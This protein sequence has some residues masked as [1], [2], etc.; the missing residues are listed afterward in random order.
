M[1]QLLL[2]D[3]EGL[4]PLLQLADLIDEHIEPFHDE[5]DLHRQ[6]LSSTPQGPRVLGGFFE[7]LRRRS[8]EAPAAAFPEQS[9]QPAEVDFSQLLGGGKLSQHRATGGAK[10]VGERVLILGEGQIEKTDETLLF[11]HSGLSA[12]E[13]QAREVTQLLHLVVGDG[14]HFHV[15]FAQH[16]VDEMGVDTVGLGAPNG[17]IASGGD[18]QRIEDCRRRTRPESSLRTGTIQ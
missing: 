12:F 3:H 8:A 10:E 13:T 11:A 2:V 9:G 17:D 14:A 15:G 1:Q 18:D 4:E 7:P 16:Q 6:G 5:A